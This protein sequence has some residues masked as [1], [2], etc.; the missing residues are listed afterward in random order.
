MTHP[1]R[2]E[3]RWVLVEMI[4]TKLILHFLRLVSFSSQLRRN[5]A[6]F[7][8]PLFTTKALRAGLGRYVVELCPLAMP[9]RVTAFCDH[10]LLHTGMAFVFMLGLPHNLM[11]S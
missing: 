2:S 9:P 3:F 11:V 1:C 7:C 5:L 8:C 4:T 10:K 6:S